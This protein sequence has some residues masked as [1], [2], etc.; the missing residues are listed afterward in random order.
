MSL[1]NM[2]AQAQKEVIDNWGWYL[3]IFWI[4]ASLVEVSPVKIYPIKYIK[5]KLSMFLSG[6]IESV[7]KDVFEKMNGEME[8][9]NKEIGSIKSDLE[10]YR[11]EQKIDKVKSLRKEMLSFG[12]NLYNHNHDQK[13]SK[14]SFEEILFTTYPDYEKLIESL[15]MT[16]GLVDSTIKYINEQYEQRLRDGNFILEDD[17]KAN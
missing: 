3:I 9:L 12:D 6:F 16:N 15:D 17:D 1:A 13:F 5:N 10:E 7:N 4:C 14:R 8:N 11:K 2:I